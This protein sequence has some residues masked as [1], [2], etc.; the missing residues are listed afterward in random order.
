MRSDPVLPAIFSIVMASLAACQPDGGEGVTVP[1]NPVAVPLAWE[2]GA[3]ERRAWSEA[4]RRDFAAEL[5]RI[6]TPGD[7]ESYC[8]AWS[9][10]GT[11][12]RVE[13]LSVLA[14]AI[15]RRESGYNPATVFH[16][17]PP[18]GVDSVGL[19]QLSYEDGFNRCDLDRATDSLKDPLVNI[20]CA[21]GEM[22]R[23]MERDGVVATGSSGSDARGLARYWSVMREGPR[24][25]REE[26]RGKVRAL[27]ACAG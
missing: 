24:H 4:L 3:P 5:H 21:V 25:F 18:L 12:D 10:L 7:I 17:P 8:P 14:V 23:L 6:G 13:A 15:A 20:H 19:F 16:E 27:P 22:A 1:A 26:I 2:A 9:R 11:T